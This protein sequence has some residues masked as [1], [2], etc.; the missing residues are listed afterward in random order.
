M[1]LQRYNDNDSDSDIETVWIDSMKTKH[2]DGSEKQSASNTSRRQDSDPTKPSFT[3]KQERSAFEKSSFDSDGTSHEAPR[4]SNFPPLLDERPTPRNWSWRASS[5]RSRWQ[6]SG[7][8]W[9][10]FLQEEENKQQQQ[11]EWE[12]WQEA[13]RERQ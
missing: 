2:G 10:Q 7:L 8:G 4:T 13:T 9:N 11:L 3:R 6:R 12:I 5:Q 1:D